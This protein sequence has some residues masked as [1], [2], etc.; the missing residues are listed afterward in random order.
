MPVKSRVLILLITMISIAV[1]AG[2]DGYVLGKSKA[3]PATTT[4]QQAAAPI[5]A[6]KRDLDNSADP[7]LTEM[8]DSLQGLSGDDFDWKLI[9]YIVSMKS[10]E[11]GMLRMAET[12]AKHQELKDLAN[13]Q[14]EQNEKVLTLLFQWQKA[15]GYTDH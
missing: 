2:S 8:N 1:V 7:T 15:W 4:G 10:N 11:T 9:N 14:R 6:E 3:E 12:K 13:I 5:P